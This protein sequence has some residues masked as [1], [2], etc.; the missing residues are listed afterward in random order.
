MSQVAEIPKQGSLAANQTVIRGR[1]TEVKRTD[2]AVYTDVTL[3]APDQY[4]S[5]QNVRIVSNRFIGKPGEDITQRCAIKGY[6]RSYTDKQGQ[7]AFAV[8]ITL[9][10]IED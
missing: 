3:P 10:A 8:D 9:S 4:S 5:P 6:R 1:V 7:K 2:T